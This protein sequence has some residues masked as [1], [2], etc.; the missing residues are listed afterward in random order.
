MRRLMSNTRNPAPARSAAPSGAL[1][2]SLA[3]FFCAAA[4]FCV[5]LPWEGLRAQ[6][7]DAPVPGQPPTPATPAPT[8]SPAAAPATASTATPTPAAAP[9]RKKS[10]NPTGSPLDT[11]MSTR[12]YADVPEAK[13]FVRQNRPPPETLDFKPTTGTDPARPKVRTKPELDALQSE[14]E[15]AAQ[16]NE[17]RAGLR[18]AAKPLKA[19]LNL[20][21]AQNGKASEPKKPLPN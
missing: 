14:L 7:F 17:E 13:D 9:Q 12:L 20:A 16:K 5:V 21:G 1:S 4:L 19:P 3:A 10:R 8:D 15:S 2:C 6:T 18:K 11:L